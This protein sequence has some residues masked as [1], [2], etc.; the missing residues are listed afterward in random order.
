MTQGIDAQEGQW[1][2]RCNLSKI[3]PPRTSEEIRGQHFTLITTLEEATTYE[4][5]I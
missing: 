1:K 2:E 4:K 3:G 5:R